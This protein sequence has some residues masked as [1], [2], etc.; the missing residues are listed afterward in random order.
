M[1]APFPYGET[2]EVERTTRNDF[3]DNAYVVSHSIVGCAFD[4]GTTTE[5]NG[6]R[7]TVVSKPRGFGPYDADLR[8][9]D[10]I[11]RPGPEPRKQR[12]YRIQGAIKRYKNPFNGWTPGFEV[13]LE[14]V[15]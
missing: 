11:V 8:P 2:W 15:S 10:R 1:S 13:G 7:I 3:G 14:Q 12:T 5:I 6:D 4:P 9:D